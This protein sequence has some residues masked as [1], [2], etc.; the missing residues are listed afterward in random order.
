MSAFAAFAPSP[1][2]GRF[3]RNKGPPPPP[4]PS[5]LQPRLAKAVLRVSLLI[6][7]AREHSHFEQSSVGF[8][9]SLSS[10]LLQLVARGS[11][12]SPIS[13]AGNK[14]CSDSQTLLS[15]AWASLGSCSPLYRVPEETQLGPICSSQPPCVSGKLSKPLNPDWS[16]H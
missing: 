4:T 14:G 7:K 2:A 8:T 11:P 9:G 12:P 5:G 1:A 13:S 3:L 16:P 15:K 6:V 10:F